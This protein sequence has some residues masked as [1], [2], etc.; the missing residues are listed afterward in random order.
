[1]GYKSF[2]IVLKRITGSEGGDECVF[3]NGVAVESGTSSA[4]RP[5]RKRARVPENVGV[6]S[7]RK[8]LRIVCA[9]G[10]QV[11]NVDTPL[12]DAA[13]EDVGAVLPAVPVESGDSQIAL[14]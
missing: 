3:E 7:P 13:I 5:A 9:L 4:Q 12:V 11:A 1:M 14:E 2:A 6:C 8:V 10:A